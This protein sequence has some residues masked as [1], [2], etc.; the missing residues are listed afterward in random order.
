MDLAFVN[1]RRGWLLAV[2]IVCASLHFVPSRAAPAPPPPAAVQPVADTYFGTTVVDNYR[3]MEAEPE[4]QFRAMVEGQSAYAHAIIDAIPGRDRLEQDIAAMDGQRTVLLTVALAHG[5]RF[6]LKRPPGSE[7]GKLYV[8]DAATGKETLLVDPTAYGSAGHHATIDQFA[9]S[10]DGQLVAYTLSLGGSEDS[11]LHVVSARTGKVRSEAIDRADA[12]GVSWAPD[13]RSF[14][15]TRLAKPVTGAA[16]SARFDHQRVYRHELGADPDTDQVVLDADHLPFA[17]KAAQIWPGVTIT[18]GSEAVIAEIA[19]GTGI[20]KALF[21]ARLA[22]VLAGRPT[23]KTVAE[24][25]DGVTVF[26]VHGD[27]IYLL[28]HHAAPRYEVVTENLA[29]PDFATAKVVAPERAG[30]I[31]GIAASSEALYVA[32][33]TGGGMTLARQPYGSAKLDPIALPFA[34]T[35]FP[36]SEDAGALSADPTAPGATFALESWVRPLAWLSYD[37]RTH[38]VRD[39]G[40]AGKFAID[41]SAYDTL[42][43]AA[44][45]PDGT[46]VPL[47]IVFKRGIS[48]DH[49]H[50]TV[51][52][53]YGSFGVSLDPEFRPT[54]TP[55]LDRGGVYAVAHVRGGGE[56]GEPW[57]Q[58]GM[59]AAKQN[60]VTD[61][62]AC[63]EALIRLGYTSPA[64]LAAEGASA[65]G[66]TV[67]VA[68]TRRPDLFRAALI[69]AGAV[70]ALRLER[71]PVGPNLI[72]EFGSVKD[73]D[74]FRALL[75]MD[76]YQQVRD[77]TPYP[78]VLLTD[79]FNDPRI[80]VWMPAKMTARLEAA[81]TSGRPILFR[82][83][84]DAGHGAGSTRSQ[85]DAKR[86]DELAFLLWQLGAPSFQA[87]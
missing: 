53:G 72:P 47:S 84:F 11:T 36:P 75:A 17:F 2:G 26:C 64:H 40:I 67:G 7:S 23:W 10:Q 68:I 14:F 81:S 55:W 80:Q 60:T 83:D 61:F 21:T 41:L 74:Q 24:Q 20:D 43:T 46:M 3:W 45:A 19:D 50:P 82:V 31:T 1:G 32:E 57:H 48:L 42:E 70:N 8:S 39:T 9:P 27:K 38:A 79:G 18:P 63:A 66:I 33:R 12:A 69:G 78:A 34:G 87:P 22:D 59:L 29:A 4:P 54:L 77:G 58:G 28:T 16:A 25:K 30:V 71:L 73:P 85:N 6:Y 44:K 49:S 35:I 15:Y 51:L 52:L 62:I 5:K 76:A 65:G 56:L 37:P 13:G 86:A